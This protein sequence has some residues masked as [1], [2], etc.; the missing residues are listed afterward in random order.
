M[1]IVGKLC[2]HY[3]SFS[4][5]TKA[6]LWFVA[7]TIIDKAIAVLTQPFINR[8]LS[9]GEVGI[10]G[11]YNSWYSVVSI[12]ATFNL[13][14]GVLEVYLTKE[15]AYKEKV[16]SSLSSLCILISMFFA[17]ICTI[18]NKDVVTFSGLKSIYIYLMIFTALSDALIQFWAVPKRYEY[19]YKEYSILIVTLFAIKSVL[20]V[21]LAWAFEDDRVLGRILGLSIPQIIVAII[22]YSRI[23]KKTGIRQISRYW[24]KALLFNLPL[25]PHYL[26]TVILSSSDRIIIQKLTSDAHAGLYSVAYSFSSLALIV[27]SS[28]NSAYN[29]FSMRAIKNHEYEKLSIVTEKIVAVSVLFSL[30]M[31]LLAP[32]GLYILGGDRYLEA[33]SI[34]PILVVGIF[35][36]T[37]YYVF[38]NIEFVYE[39][40]KYIFP[41]TVIGAFINVF[42]NYLLIPRYGYEVAAYTTLIGYIIIALSHYIVSYRIVKKDIFNIKRVSVWLICLICGSAITTVLY[43]WFSILRYII[44]AI[45]FLVVIMYLINDKDLTSTII[46]RR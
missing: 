23:I 18:F 35:F 19:S 24:K 11:V 2:E 36:S 41:I 43:S 12:I 26:S 6:S 14:G 27:F 7:V 33:K 10:Y 16:I 40:T 45:I 5:I 31:M 21:V 28:I 4:L 22:I 30:I 9:V 39:K 13:F 32:E 3:K 37:F 44:V 38:S 46:K 8:I 34:V 1:R 15:E 29:P 17:I 20:S 42:L 25:I